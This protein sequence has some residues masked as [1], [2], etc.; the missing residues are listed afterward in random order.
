MYPGWLTG[1]ISLLGVSDVPK[2]W[3][4]YKRDL[5]QKNPT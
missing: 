4:I 3:K 2:Q 5:Y 1:D